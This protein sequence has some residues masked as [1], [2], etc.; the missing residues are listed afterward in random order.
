MN[1]SKIYI[2]ICNRGKLNRNLNC[3]TEK[4]H[5]IPKCMGGNNDKDNITVLTFREHYL[6]HWLLCKMYNK[7]IG[8]NYAFLCMLRKQPTGERILTSRRYENIKTNFK[9]FKSWHNKISNPGAHINTRNSSKKRMSDPNR[10]PIS[11]DPSK[12]RTC[13]PIKVYF[14]DGTI[15]I[16]QY[17]KQCC[18][19]Y[20]IPYQ[21][22]KYWLRNNK[23]KSNK[24]K[25][26]K[27]E[28]LTK[29]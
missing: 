3:Y 26:I 13:Q 24:H 15:K 7:H 23:S 22:M 8:I 2:D 12:N 21:T 27:I 28:K 18:L 11:V 10:N 9:K 6:V 1:Y 20:N 17:A 29:G 14:E 5:I 16:Y 25:I 19:E 4:H